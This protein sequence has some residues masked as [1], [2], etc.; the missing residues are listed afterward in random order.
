MHARSSA[1]C[2]MALKTYVGLVLVDIGRR[3]CASFLICRPV[4]TNMPARR[5]R[6]WEAAGTREALAMPRQTAS[7]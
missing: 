4:Q 6:A 3:D 2:L 5:L 7:A 1:S